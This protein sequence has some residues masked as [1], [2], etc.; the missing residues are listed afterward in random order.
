MT[1][2]NS[3]TTTSGR[4][5]AFPVIAWA[6]LIAG[7][8]DISSAFLLAYLKGVGPTGVLQGVATGLI[9]REVAIHGGLATAGLGLAIHFVI[10]FV[11]ASVFYAASRKLIF[12][13]R[14]PIISG[15]L[16]GVVVYGFMYW[17]VMPLAYPVVHPSLSRDVTAV[18]VHMLL[19]GLPI[20][21]IVR[22]HSRSQLSTLNLLND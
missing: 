18:C 3:A 12:L 6:T 21:L 1:A 16:Y 22:G 5:Q 20:S 11:V 14:H 17:I 8:L 19:I 7:V 15:L 9:G 10:A 4:S 13:T 2:S